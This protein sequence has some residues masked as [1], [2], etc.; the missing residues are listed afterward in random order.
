MIITVSYKRTWN[1]LLANH[2]QYEYLIK[3]WEAGLV[4]SGMLIICNLN[5]TQG[6]SSK[7]NSS[8]QSLDFYEVCI[9]SLDLY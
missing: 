6:F 3:P 7:K 9:N 1:K 2:I 5:I 4:N 8:F